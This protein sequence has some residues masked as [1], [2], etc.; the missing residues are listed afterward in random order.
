MVALYFL[1]DL[2]L[3]IALAIF[4]LLVRYVLIKRHNDRH[5]IRHA[6]DGFK[7]V[8]LEDET[9]K[10]E[11]ALAPIDHSSTSN[12]NMDRGRYDEN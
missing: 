7:N 4:I 2:I 9:I 12:Q 1:I 6:V 10:S 8:E 11:E 5:D 3:F